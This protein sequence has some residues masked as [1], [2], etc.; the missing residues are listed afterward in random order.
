MIFLR[1][2]FEYS[3]YQDLKSNEVYYLFSL[4]SLR[5]LIDCLSAIPRQIDSVTRIIQP[6]Q[7]I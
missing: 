3:L 5:F 4:S 7:S 6:F 2:V 1:Y